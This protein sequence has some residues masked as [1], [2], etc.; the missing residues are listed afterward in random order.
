MCIQACVAGPS[1]MLARSRAFRRALQRSRRARCRRWAGKQ[2]PRAV[3]GR[4]VNWQRCKPIRLGTAGAVCSGKRARAYVHAEAYAYLP[5][6]IM[7]AAPAQKQ[8]MTTACRSADCARSHTP[9]ELSAFMCSIAT[10][11]SMPAAMAF[12]MPRENR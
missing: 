1:A 11:S 12:T 8:R 2:G 6:P 9:C 5:M 3:N 7:A 10:Y 4:A